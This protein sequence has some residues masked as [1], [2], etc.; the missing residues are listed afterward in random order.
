MEFHWVGKCVLSVSS[1]A[2]PKR[3]ITKVQ[4]K[5]TIKMFCMADSC[6][7]IFNSFRVSKQV[8]KKNNRLK[9]RFL[10]Y[11]VLNKRR[12]LA[13]DIRVITPAQCADV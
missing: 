12:C 8:S 5:Y 6:S 2:F 3:Q 4:T 9:K 11:T 10:I 7:Y 1:A 13:C